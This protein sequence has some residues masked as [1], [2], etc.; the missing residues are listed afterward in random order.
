[1]RLQ[2]KTAVITGAA[3]GIGRA[4]AQLFVR[5]GARVLLIDRSEQDLQ[6]VATALGAAAIFQVADVADAKAMRGAIEVALGHFGVID[7]FVANAGIEGVIAPLVDYPLDVFDQ[8]LNVNVRGVLLGI[9]AVL[10]HMSAR[11]QGSIIVTASAGARQGAPGMAAYIASKH[12]VT[13]LMK[14][15]AIEAATYGVRVNTVNPGSVATPMIRRIQEGLSPGHAEEAQ[16]ARMAQMPMGR[17]A[18]PEDV[19]QTMLFLASDDSLYCSGG[20]YPV[21]GGI[22]AR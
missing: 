8:V 5:E 10:P 18:E 4:T 9:Q 6:A 7:I 1:M 13:G 19:A 21:D 17:F 11:R 16:R 3:S 12:A 20:Q 22:S 15:A 14:V 2:G